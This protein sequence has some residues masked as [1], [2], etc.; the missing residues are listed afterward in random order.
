VRRRE[1]AIG[2]A[3]VLAVVGLF[4]WRP[5]FLERVEYQLYD[6]RFRLRG[7]EPPKAP[8]GIVAVDARSVDEFG[9]WPWRRSVMARLVD[10]LSDAG[11]SAI[12]FDIVFSEPETPPE[13]EPLRAVVAQLSGGQG[14]RQV[15]QVLDGAIQAADTDR[16]L[17][18]A[19]R[20]SDRVVLGYFFRTT[21]DSGV[22]GGE[23]VDLPLEQSLPM[24]R[25]SRLLTGV[26]P[27]NVRP[28]P[29][30]ECTSVEPSLA[31]FN[32]AARRAGFFNAW[33]DSDGVVRRTSLIARCGGEY[34]KSLS[35][36]LLELHRGQKAQLVWDEPNG[37]V[38]GLK[39]GDSLIPMDEGGRV[40]VNFRGPP[41]TFPHY[42]AIDVIFGRVGD[43]ELRDK[44]VLIGPTETGI[45]D[46]YPSPFTNVA[47]G[48]EVHANVLDN[49]MAGDVLRRRDD[50]ILV[51]LAAVVVLGLATMI[52]V[53]LLGTAVRA[54]AFAAVLLALLV[55]VGAWAFLGH[56]LVLVVAYPAL[57]VVATYLAMAITHGSAQEARTRWIR[58][59]FAQFVPPEVVNEMIE[60]PDSFEVGGQRKDLSILFSDIRSFTTIAEELGPD[61]TTK[62]L[63]AYLTP[64]TKIVFDSRGT[65]DKYIGDAIVAFWGAPLPVPDHPR[66]AAEAALAMQAAVRRMRETRPDL[67]GAE[68]LHI[69][70]GI[71]SAEVNVGKMGSELRFDYTAT[72]DGMNL[73][74]RLEGMTKQ[75]GSA[76]LASEDLVR[77]LPDGF[78]LRELDAIRVKG[79]KDGVRIFEV[80]GTG[81]AE[82]RDK[83]WLDAYAA[84]LAAY[85]AGDWDAAE[86]AFHA[87]RAAHEAADKACDLIL[88]RIERLRAAPPSTWDGIWTFETK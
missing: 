43:E 71:H 75:Y 32:D 42:S 59:T 65:L 6:W 70:I 52:A 31:R 82:G 17:E 85:R 56:G 53:P 29:I 4:A 88:E 83:E 87:A 77:R 48:V 37:I 72:G 36:S 80:L 3:V 14:S 38:A 81:A 44:L 1:L 12:G 50:L 51:E 63:N 19:I 86:R 57:S 25:K 7:P 27:P 66:H 68:R 35:L 45:K 15:L 74:S 13:I 64:M 79:K 2:L 40:L 23:S 26:L 55:G 21:H 84:A 46:L 58:N 8:I 69:G 78:R 41:R 60:R 61:D 34:Y 24:V 28:A 33:P 62:L 16:H 11:V 9:R 22:D 5:E 18:E 73:C 39:I 30:L 76:I 49:L 10:R 54:A 47:P 20:R 67:R